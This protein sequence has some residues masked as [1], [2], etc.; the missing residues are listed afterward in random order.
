MIDV[1][2]VLELKKQL[3]MPDGEIIDISCP[4]QQLDLGIKK[5]L[6]S[7]NIGIGGRMDC[8]NRYDE[9]CCPH[10]WALRH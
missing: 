1:T 8:T 9:L 4:V 3:E 2:F 10:P 6:P 7:H 5:E